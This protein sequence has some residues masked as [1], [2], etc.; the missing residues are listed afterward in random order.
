MASRSIKSRESSGWWRTP[1]GITTI[2]GLLTAIATLIGTINQA[3]WLPWHHKAANPE[4]SPAAPVAN[5]P[6][7]SRDPNDVA[8]E[9]KLI[10]TWNSTGPVPG[11]ARW[12][13]VTSYTEDG[14]FTTIGPMYYPGGSV[15]MTMGGS[16]FIKDNAFHYTIESGSL[17]QIPIGM[18]GVNKII[19]LSQDEFVSE[20]SVFGG[21]SVLHRS[22]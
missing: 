14:K 1:A 17:P 2:V 13:A 4:S 6:A 11:G 10:G 19:S 3:D 7:E 5:P 16:W 15:V 21:N 18:K 22:Q 8:I 20:N 9:R 12:D